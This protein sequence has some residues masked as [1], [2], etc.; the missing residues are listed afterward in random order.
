MGYQVCET[1]VVLEDCF[2]DC[3]FEGITMNFEGCHDLGGYNFALNFDPVNTINDFYNLYIN[4]VLFETFPYEGLTQF[5]ANVGPFETDHFLVTICDNDNPGCC[6]TFEVAT[7]DC[8]GNNDCVI[9][10]VIV[11]AHDCNADGYFFVDLEV[12]GENFGN[13]GFSV[14]GNGNDYGDFS[15]E[16]PYITLGPFA[17][18]GESVYEF[19]VIDNQYE[20]CSNYGVIGP[21]DCD[22]EPCAFE[23]GYEEISCNS[24]LFFTNLE[25]NVDWKVNGDY[26]T[27]SEAFE[28]EAPHPG[29]YEICAFIETP[30]CPMGY[31]VCESV[32]VPEDCFDDCG[33]NDI[34]M[35]FEGCN[36]NGS[37][38]YNL[39]FIPVNPTNAYFDLYIQNEFV[40]YYAYEEM[41]IWLEGIGP[42]EGDHFV[43]KVCDND[44]PDCC[45]VFEVETPECGGNGCNFWDV[46][47]APHIA[48]CNNGVFS[49]DVA[50]NSSNTGPLGYYIFANGAIFG[51]FSYTLPF[52]TIGPFEGDGI[53]QYD[54][55][56]L[57]IMNPACYTY[58][59]FGTF[60]CDEDVWP[61]DTN[62]DNIANHFDLL[63]IGIAYGAEGPVR[64]DDNTEWDAM[65]ANS[66]AQFF[67]DNTNFKHADTNGDGVVNS[68]DISAIHQNFL[69]THG[70]VTTFNPLPGTEIDPPVY[71]D[72][73]DNL[74]TGVPFE[75]PV[76]LGTEGE[77]VNDIYGIAFSIEIDPDIINIQDMEI[78]FPTSWMGEP[79][80]NIITFDRIDEESST[81]YVA[82]S[83]NDQ[84]NVSG[85][86][87]ILYLHGIIDDIA[88]VHGEMDLQATR[89][90]AIDLAQNPIPLNNPYKTSLI[91]KVKDRD[92]SFVSLLRE[93]WIT[94]NPATNHISI[95]NKNYVAVDAVSI[96]DMSGIQYGETL[97]NTN[98]IS[99][100]QLPA[101]MYALKL[102]MAGK[103]I[104]KKLVKVQR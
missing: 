81:L 63:N 69:F 68:E 53:T 26:I 55:L 50:F 2:N 93:T 9:N 12:V 35:N 10:H 90:N 64:E 75:I 103:V 11:E 58:Y 22:A 87:P 54:F 86:G 4:D 52:V 6:T 74:S 88:G 3:G 15:Y 37:Y 79:G 38:N 28:F 25:L 101:G 83:R 73:P 66:W 96:Y 5:I 34:A 41:P 16:E 62:Y 14:L 33:F 27:F 71:M 78:S 1:V 17:G 36:D 91:T 31:V 23:L 44:N 19:V 97:H 67:E 82:I 65:P 42:F 46:A 76:M 32:F 99:I 92:A 43:V 84:N 13:Q 61:G 47:V 48:D 59:E 95:M 8:G 60:E 51:P 72:V 80:V 104:M 102:E 45:Q 24:F 100:D 89:I 18:D 20:G 85:Y 7:P 29:E 57:D 21:I 94:P 40:G 77:P 39:S 56:I 49:V 30:D 70:D 98:E